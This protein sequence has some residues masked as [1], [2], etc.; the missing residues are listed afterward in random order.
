MI[1]LPGRVHPLIALEAIGPRAGAGVDRVVSRDG[2]FI[3]AGIAYMFASS[4]SPM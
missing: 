2:D 1:R 4:Q 3:V